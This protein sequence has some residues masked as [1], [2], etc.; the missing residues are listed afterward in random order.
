MD[1]TINSM[2]IRLG[3]HFLIKKYNKLIYFC[4]SGTPIKLRIFSPRIQAWHF[5]LALLCINNCQNVFDCLCCGMLCL[6]QNVVIVVYSFRFIC[7]YS[8]K[9]KG[10]QEYSRDGKRERY[11]LHPLT[12]TPTTRTY[13]L[14]RQK[15]QERIGELQLGMYR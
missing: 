14:E 6:L 9:L 10:K 13:M 1:F 12:N 3:F 2:K 4:C 7:L 11:T 15:I 8:Y 5:N